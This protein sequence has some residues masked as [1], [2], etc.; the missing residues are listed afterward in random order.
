MRQILSM[1]IIAALLVCAVVPVHAATSSYYLPDLQLSVDIPTEYDVFTLDMDANDPLFSEYGTT[2]SELNSQLSAKN[3]YLNAVD[4]DGKEEIVITM[5]DNIISDFE[6]L[7]DTVLLTMA[8]AVEGEYEKYGIE[9]SKYDIY[10]HS[11]V[12]FVRLYFH[13]SANS[14]YGLQYYTVYNSK[15]VNLTLRSYS[16]PISSSQENT[17][18]SIIKSVEIDNYSPQSTTS[19]STAAFTHKDTATGASFTVP[20]NWKEESLSKDRE[21]IDVKFA[22]TKESGLVIMYG[23][24]DLW[25]LLPASERVGYTRADVDNSIF[26]KADVAEM[27]GTLGTVTTKTYN[28]KEYYFAE[29]T[30]TSDTYGVN[31]SVTMTHVLRIE[32]GWAYWFQFGG[33]SSSP[34]FKDFEQLIKSVDYPDYVKTTPDGNGGIII[35]ILI[36]VGG[37][38]LAIVL[39]SRKKRAEREKYLSIEYTAQVPQQQT[40]SKPQPI[41]QLPQK[42]L[43]YCHKCGSELPSDSTFCHKCG[44]KIPEV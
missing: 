32:N 24:T 23:S 37:I 39:I 1:L 26:T 4:P 11:Q 34:Y 25:S 33:K 36:I 35:G 43:R 44:V 7:S 15:S 27:I 8:S 18:L 40:Q 21:Y 10:R 14:A 22:S 12:A 2:K 13:D 16:G 29:V 3:I 6:G 5:A 19:E 38:I 42:D 30:T 9:V 31:L 41:P 17:M 28:G 20:A